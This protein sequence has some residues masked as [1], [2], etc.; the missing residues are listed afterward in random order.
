MPSAS[1]N[2]RGLGAQSMTLESSSLSSP[3]DSSWRV[4][5]QLVPAAD[6]KYT[7][8]RFFQVSY[9]VV[10]SKCI[11][12][13]THKITQRGKIHG[14]CSQYS[15]IAGAFPPSKTWQTMTSQLYKI[16]MDYV[17]VRIAI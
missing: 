17:A 14:S 11:I 3:V 13:G 10:A 15:E 16:I 12:D 7:N 2:F 4:L 1:S 9:I 5:Y 6:I 8:S